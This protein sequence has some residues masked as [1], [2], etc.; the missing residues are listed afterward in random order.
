VPAQ[1]GFEPE[2]GGL[3]VPQGIFAGTGEIA[4]G[5]IFNRRDIDGGEIT[6]AHQPRQLYGVTP[7]GVHTIAGLFGHE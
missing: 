5:F 3:E 7:V 6:R 4:H 2:L 1:E